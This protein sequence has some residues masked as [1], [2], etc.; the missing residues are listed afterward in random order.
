MRIAIL[1]YSAPPVV[2]G[3]ESVIA[4]HARLFLEAGHSVR[5]L[6]GR[7]DTFLDGIE[8]NEIPLL[9]SL[10]PEVLRLKA[11]LDMGSLPDDFYPVSKSIQDLLRRSLKGIDLLIAHNVGSLNK[12]LPLTSA[13]MEIANHP[14][15]AP[16]ILWHHDL[17]WTTPRYRNELYEGF[18]WNTLATPW[19][20]VRQYVVVSELRRQELSKLLGIQA[21]Q[22]QVIPNGV[23]IDQLLKLTDQT[24]KIIRDLRLFQAAPLLLLPVRIT[25]RKN[26]ELALHTLTHLRSKMPDAQ[27]LITGPMG[28][29]NPTNV[30]YFK[31]LQKLRDAL[32]L[33]GTAH[34]MAEYSNEFLP[35]EVIADFYKIADGLLM[36]SREE[37]FGI[38][39]LE[40]GLSGIPIF[41]SDIPPL[42]ELAGDHA[43]YFSPDE[44]PE[45]VSK[46]IYLRLK[47][48]SVFHMRRIVRQQY[49]WESIY[50]QHL[51]PLIHQAV[52][53]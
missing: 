48:D 12:N 4:H 10:H 33:N 52:R 46:L 5:I 29:H 50:T 26:I 8:Y 6:A 11:Q 47:T 9:Y 30:E 49:S 27:L 31:D 41:C 23:Q 25:R 3:V 28:P 2:G 43:D 36:T 18:P 24:R 38:P 37:G 32:Q 21:E 42:H 14:D 1:H 15:E 19:I 16:V 17:A 45:L 40:A 53:K 20:G 13:L 51:E 35:D 7:G 44:D 22:I 34:F 39:I